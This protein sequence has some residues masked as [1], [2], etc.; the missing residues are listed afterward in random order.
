MT[1][2]FSNII[3]V[4][5]SLILFLSLFISIFFIP[6]Y[7][8]TRIISTPSEDKPINKVISP[9]SGLCWPLPRLY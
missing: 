2:K 8:N 4:Y 3:K 7:N 5:L 9:T 1:S 6:F